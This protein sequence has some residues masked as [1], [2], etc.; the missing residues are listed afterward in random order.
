MADK[1]RMS[2]VQKNKASKAKNRK[3]GG[4]SKKPKKSLFKKV[5]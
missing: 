3:K 4:N 5:M 1:K 2:R